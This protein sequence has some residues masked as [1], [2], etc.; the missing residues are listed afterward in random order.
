MDALGGPRKVQLG[1]HSDEVLQVAELHGKDPIAIRDHNV[2]FPSLD[3][4]TYS[5][6]G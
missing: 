6:V 5:S 3:A 1:G 4:M 2:H